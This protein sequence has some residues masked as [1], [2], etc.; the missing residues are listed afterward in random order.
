MLLLSQLL[1]DK[2]NLGQELLSSPAGEEQLWTEG[3]HPT[4][5]RHWTRMF[6]PILTVSHATQQIMPRSSSPTR[7]VPSMEPDKEFVK[8][9]GERWRNYE[10]EFLNWPQRNL[11]YEMNYYD[12]SGGPLVSGGAVIGTVSW[13]IPCARGF[14]DA[15][16]RT[17]HFRTWI[18][19]TI[20]T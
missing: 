16:D 6:W 2:P 17:S 4:T 12:Y 5:F 11:L 9:T 10:L 18:L 20:A 8:V 19:N 13:N 7:F 3:P 1:W 14:P 15:Y